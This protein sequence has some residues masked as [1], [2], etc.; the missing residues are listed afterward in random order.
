MARAPVEVKAQ[1]TREADGA[2]GGLAMVF[3]DMTSPLQAQADANRLAAIVE[4]SYDAII[5]KTLDGRITSWNGAAEEMFGYRAHEAIGRSIR[6]LIPPE[7]A[8]EEMHILT[9]LA[10]GGR[11]SA[12]E[13]VRRTKDGRPL[14]V[15]VSISPIRDGQGR[16]IGAAKIARDISEVRRH[17]AARH[18]AERLET[19]NRQ[20]QEANR[21]KS[22]FLATMSHELRTPLNAIIGFAELLHSGAVPH[23]SP[24]Y[25]GFLD[26]IRTGGRH[27][28][29][30]INDVLDLA[31][32]ESG[33]FEFHPEP[34][35]LQQIFNEV[36]DILKIE[37]DRKHMDLRTAVDPV[38][39]DLVLDP[40]R[41]KQVL[42][43]SLERDQVHC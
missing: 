1:V 38:L 42:Y 21:V 12:F 28:L 15:S 24:K 32:V 10:R 27:L 31:K 9:E 26:H 41:L 23:D 40:G 18:K 37:I 16:I 17:E 30:L 39:T 29:Q 13:T 25:R 14:E 35:D 2:I 4:S 6:T 36:A 34:V 19:E 20:I 11:L 5:S 43:K 7:R 33:K 22:R 3:R 8:D